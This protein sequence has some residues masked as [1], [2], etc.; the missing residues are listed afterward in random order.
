MPVASLGRY[1]TERGLFRETGAGGAGLT[2]HPYGGAWLRAGLGVELA[3]AG[4]DGRKGPRGLKWHGRL[5]WVQDLEA[6][7]RSI[8]A[9]FQ[10]A[11]GE[12]FPVS[13]TPAARGGLEVELGA[14]GESE[15][16]LTWSLHYAGQFREDGDNHVLL[17]RLSKAF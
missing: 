3:A 2:V 5:A 13:G 17:G 9:H 4:G 1:T 11:P 6:A 15:A 10:S 16:G 8:E 14:S 12:S 7:E